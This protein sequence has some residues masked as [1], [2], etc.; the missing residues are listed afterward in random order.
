MMRFQTDFI[1][2]SLLSIMMMSPFSAASSISNRVF[3]G[4]NPSLTARAQLLLVLRIPTI[5][6]A[7]LSRILSAW[8]GPWTP[9]PITAIT[10]SFRIF[11]AFF[12]GNSFRVVM[13]SMTPPK[14]IFAIS[15][16]SSLIRFPAPQGRPN[17]AVRRK[18]PFII[19]Q[20][21]KMENEK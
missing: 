13:F 15:R 6:L 21:R 14:S 20:R 11:W 18:S 19:P 2:A 1:E 7:P 4:T 12:N 5:T 16:N 17:H 3:P 10:L 9:Y 8:A